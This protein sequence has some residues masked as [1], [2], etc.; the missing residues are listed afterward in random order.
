MISRLWLIVVAMRAVCVS[1]LFLSVSAAGGVHSRV[2]LN[3]VPLNGSKV[4]TASRL[5]D[6]ELLVRSAGVTHATVE[7]SAP[8]AAAAPPTVQSVSP[9]PTADGSHQKRIRRPHTG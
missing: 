9:F 7:R 1:M 5:T 6:A 2:D 4:T 3:T 8:A